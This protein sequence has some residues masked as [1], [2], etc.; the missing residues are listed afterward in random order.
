MTEM[1]RSGIEVIPV[2]ADNGSRKSRGEDEVICGFADNGGG[3]SRRNHC[4]HRGILN[5]IKKS[6]THGTVPKND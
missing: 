3:M 5:K 4:I 6:R 2:F 1:Q